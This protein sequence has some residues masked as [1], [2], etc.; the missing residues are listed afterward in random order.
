M[1]D[2]WDFSGFTDQETKFGKL[3]SRFLMVDCGQVQQVTFQVSEDY[4]VLSIA[5]C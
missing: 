5:V 4:F 2:I 3:A 1:P